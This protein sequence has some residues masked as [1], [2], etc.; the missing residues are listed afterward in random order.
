[1]TEPRTQAAD[2]LWR[3]PV[4]ARSHLS[5]LSPLRHSVPLPVTAGSSTGGD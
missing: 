3:S 2:A 5:P 1:M 4:N